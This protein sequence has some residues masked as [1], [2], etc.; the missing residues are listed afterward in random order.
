MS[1]IIERLLEREIERLKTELID[2]HNDSYIRGFLV[3]SKIEVHVISIGK[4][5]NLSKEDIEE[6]RTKVKNQIGLNDLSLQYKEEF[7]NLINLKK[8]EYQ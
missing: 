2:H 7:N 1:K 4:E 3:G 8:I 5:V 6:I